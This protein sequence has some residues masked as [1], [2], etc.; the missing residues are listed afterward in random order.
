MKPLQYH[1]ASLGRTPRS[2]AIRSRSQRC[3]FGLGFRVLG[4]TAFLLGNPCQ[5]FLLLIA[6]DISMKKLKTA[7]KSPAPNPKV[8]VWGLGPFLHGRLRSNALRLCL[9]FQIIHCNHRGH[10]W[11]L[12]WPEIWSGLPILLSSPMD[13]SRAAPSWDPRPA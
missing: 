8:G 2:L 1:P 3:F 11:V 9:L 12:G 4:L 6:L 10:V 7:V 13:Y 5:T